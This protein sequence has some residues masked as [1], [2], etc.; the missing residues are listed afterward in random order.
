MSDTTSTE[1]EVETPE[2]VQSAIEKLRNGEITS[3]KD[4]AKALVAPNRA[5]VTSTTFEP[6]VPRN[7]ALDNAEVEAVKKLPEVYGAVVPTE[8]RML[9]QIEIDAL[10]EEREVLTKIE[11]AIAARKDDIRLTILNHADVE[12][13]SS[14]DVDHETDD[15][16]QD[17]EGH[18]IR[19]ASYNSE[20]HSKR[21]SVETRAGSI[22]ITPQAIKALSEDPESDFTHDDYLKSTTQVR[23]FDEHKFMLLL[24]QRPE[25]MTAL[26]PAV[27]ESPGGVS[28]YLRNQKK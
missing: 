18:Y 5:L 2:H 10:V 9:E 21:F 16:S 25:L 12:Y 24:K 22:S 13:E 26:A 19:P 8:R 3:V 7:I 17:G 1:V 28:V 15:V 11:K 4:V 20:A 14:E 6:K 23:Q 27:S